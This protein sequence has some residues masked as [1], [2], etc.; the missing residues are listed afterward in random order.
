[1]TSQSLY[2]GL[3]TPCDLTANLISY[4]SSL[5]GLLDVHRSWQSHYIFRAFIFSVPQS[6]PLIKGEARISSPAVKLQSHCFYPLSLANPWHVSHY[7]ILYSFSFCL[8]GFFSPPLNYKL[9][10]GQDFVLFIVQCLAHNWH[11][12]NIC[13]RNEAL[14]DIYGTMANTYVL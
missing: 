7:L 5:P 4:S 6:R 8:F 2:N 11:S 1:M 12:I 14:A 3:T 10:K 9:H 13:R